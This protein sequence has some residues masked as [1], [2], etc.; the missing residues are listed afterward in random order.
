MV[1]SSALLGF[2]PFLFVLFVLLYLHHC[3]HSEVLS[4]TTRTR[5]HCLPGLSIK[6]Q[7]QQDLH[8]ANMRLFILLITFL[9][10]VAA[11]TLNK[12]DGTTIELGDEP[13]VVDLSNVIM[14][15]RAPVTESSAHNA[16]DATDVNVADWDRGSF[17]PA[18]QLQRQ[19]RDGLPLQGWHE[20]LHDLVK[21]KRRSLSSHPQ[22]AST[23]APTVRLTMGGSFI[24]SSTVLVTVNPRL[25]PSSSTARLAIL[26]PILRPLAATTRSSLSIAAGTNCEYQVGKAI[27]R[28]AHGASDSDLSEC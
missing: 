3:P 23:F 8:P 21:H 6:P 26:R 4:R 17:L 14:P 20:Q 1:Y 12:I 9:S 7:P 27:R 15:A 13:A 11:L 22:F 5:T 2:W 10:A 19:C 25:D 24:A 16:R 18:H 28:Y